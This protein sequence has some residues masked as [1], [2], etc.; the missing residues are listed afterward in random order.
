VNRALD[1][2][3]GDVSKDAAAKDNVSRDGSSVGIGHAS[4]RL[5][6]LDIN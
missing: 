1:V 4:I 2:T 5:N 6:N 3:A